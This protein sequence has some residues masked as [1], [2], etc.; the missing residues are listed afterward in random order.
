MTPSVQVI[1]KVICFLAFWLILDAF[2]G[3]GNSLLSVNHVAFG[4]LH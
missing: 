4:A 3:L 2:Y 1:L